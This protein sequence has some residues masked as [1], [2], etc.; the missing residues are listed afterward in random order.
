MIRAASI[1]T[2]MLLVILES[3]MAT[4]DLSSRASG[5]YPGPVERDR[6]TTPYCSEEWAG[7]R[8]DAQA[9]RNG[10]LKMLCGA[11]LRNAVLSRADLSNANLLL[12]DLAGADL[13]EANLSGAILARAN[14]S[15]AWLFKA[16]LNGALLVGADLSSALL[17]DVDLSGTKDWTEANL[18]KTYFGPT[19]LPPVVEIAHARHL[20]SL[21]FSTW[22]GAL[23]ALREEFKKA[24][25]R[26]QER[27]VTFAIQ[28]TRAIRAWYSPLDFVDTRG[29]APSCPAKEFASFADHWPDKLDLGVSP[30]G[31]KIESVFSFVM[32]NLPSAYG[33]YPGRPLRILGA[34]LLLFTVPYL[35]ALHRYEGGGIWVIA[36]ADRVRKRKVRGDPMVRLTVRSLAREP[37]RALFTRGYML[38]PLRIGLRIA[39]AAFYF[40]LLSAFAIG[41]REFNVGIWLTRIQRREYTL[42]A[43]G[44][45]RTVSGLQALMSVYLVALWVL[46]YF[47]RPFE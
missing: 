44:W 39:A 29:T 47:G 3:A 37:N 41:W 23:S 46:T 10:A 45:V 34:L 5:P 17:I 33:M 31:D 40:S 8:P 14:L 35:I 16:N 12:A 1:A 36:L 11:N 25:L 13:I 42:R 32:F 15:M 9:V 38:V 43:T 6:R 22:P 30:L 24:G 4:A 27:Q 26:D 7:R 20:W 18:C 19:A 28:R 2:T 21:R